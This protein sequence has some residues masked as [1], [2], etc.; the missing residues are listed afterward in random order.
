MSKKSVMVAVFGLLMLLVVSTK[1]LGADV[2]G[3]WRYEGLPDS[4][5]TIAQDGN[6]VYI[7]AHHGISSAPGAPAAVI[8]YGIGVIDGDKIE[9][10]FKVVRRPNSTWGGANGVTYEDL[11]VSPDG[12]T[13]GGTWRN[14]V[15]QGAAA[16]LI[17]VH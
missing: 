9:V 2:T 16:K 4:E 3:V 7:S 5:V 15:G 10:Q 6:L 8:S 12:K 14:D 1:G 11:T 13:L 17:R